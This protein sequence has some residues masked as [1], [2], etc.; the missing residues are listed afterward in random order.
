MA[1]NLISGPHAGNTILHFDLGIP[2]LFFLPILSFLLIFLFFLSLTSLLS[3]FNN[4]KSSNFYWT[5]VLTI[6]PNSNFTFEIWELPIFDD[7]EN[8]LKILSSLLKITQ[9]TS[10]RVIQILNKNHFLLILKNIK[11]VFFPMRLGR[12]TSVGSQ[13]F[14]MPSG[15]SVFI[16]LFRRIALLGHK[17][18]KIPS[19]SLGIRKF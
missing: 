8:S 9:F 15:N 13:S 10:G 3:S 17:D 4:V 16:F 2:N 6:L 1:L 7:K 11:V 14:Y 5:L 18:W 19:G 12:L